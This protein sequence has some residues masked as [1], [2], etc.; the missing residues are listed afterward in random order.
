MLSWQ[1]NASQFEQKVIRPIFFLRVLLDSQRLHSVIGCSKPS[2]E[3]T[4]GWED[5]QDTMRTLPGKSGRRLCDGVSSLDI[6]PS[7]TKLTSGD[8]VDISSLLRYVRNSH[9]RDYARRTEGVGPLE[10]PPFA[11]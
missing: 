11:D 8:T 6:L 5:P 10:A 4:D 3:R 7:R 2:S 9:K 1:M